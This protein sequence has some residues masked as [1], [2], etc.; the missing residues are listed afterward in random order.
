MATAQ[1]IIGKWTIVAP[2][3]GS[4]ERDWNT[5][6]LIFSTPAHKLLLPKAQANWDWIGVREWRKETAV[7]ETVR[8]I[9]KMVA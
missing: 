9:K 6:D 1:I 2:Y 3:I 8:A 4:E 7:K 5:I